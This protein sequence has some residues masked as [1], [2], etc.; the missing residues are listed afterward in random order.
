VSEH[1]GVFREGRVKENAEG[2]REGE[3]AHP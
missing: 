2:A 1:G 3:E